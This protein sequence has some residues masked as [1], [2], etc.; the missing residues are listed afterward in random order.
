MAKVSAIKDNNDQL[1]L[2]IKV[3]TLDEIRCLIQFQ[4][5]HKNSDLQKNYEHLAAAIIIPVPTDS[6]ECENLF[7]DIIDIFAVNREEILTQIRHP[8][9]SAQE[10]NNN[11]NSSD[12]P[13]DPNSSIK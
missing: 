4:Q 13:V 11:E 5:S 10:E 9:R 1:K 8:K 12:Y 2:C 6:G 3:Q 7:S